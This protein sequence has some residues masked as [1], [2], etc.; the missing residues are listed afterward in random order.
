MP[1]WANACHRRGPGNEKNIKYLPPLNGPV[2]QGMEAIY[3]LHGNL[4]IDELNGGTYNYV[5]PAYPGDHPLVF[6]LRGSGHLAVDVLPY[7]ALGNGRT[8]HRI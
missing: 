7:L 3:N 4:V 8:V 2:D 6:V 1:D 5:A